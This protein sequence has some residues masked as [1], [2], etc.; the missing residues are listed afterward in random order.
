MPSAEEPG[1]RAY[2]QFR[3][4][5]LLAC[6]ALAFGGAAVVVDIAG[7]GATPVVVLL[8]AAALAAGLCLAALRAVLMEGRRERAARV[9]TESRRAGGVAERSR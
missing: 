7:G 8:A 3:R 9:G 1:W 4:I 5:C 2:A 6:I